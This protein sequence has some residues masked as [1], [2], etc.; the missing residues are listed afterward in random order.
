MDSRLRHLL[1]HPLDVQDSDLALLQDK[2]E[3]YPYFSTLR[4]LL[5]FGIKDSASGAYQKELKK[6]SVYSP[7]RVALYH[8]LQ[9]EKQEEQEI[10]GPITSKVVEAI[11][12]VTELKVEEIKTDSSVPNEPVNEI[13]KEIDTLVT[14]EIPERETS[15]DSSSNRTFSEWLSLVNSPPSTKASKESTLPTE[16]DIKYQLI[17]EFIEKSPK[18]T[19]I[20]QYEEPK[21]GALKSDNGSEYSDLMTETLAQIYTQQKM[22]DKAIKAYKILCLKY[23][24]KKD[25]FEN[26][27]A[28]IEFQQNS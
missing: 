21:A 2:I 22:F 6:A 8:Y 12:E 25:L 27:I 28:E 17:D 10:D 15:F 14:E 26:K 9:K 20:S 13:S 16:K 1:N 23:P 3:K 19:P 4:S 11:P 5:L 18:I 24:D 7:S